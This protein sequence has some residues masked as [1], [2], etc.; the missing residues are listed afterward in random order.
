MIK[1][2]QL[3]EQFQNAI[4]RSQKEVKQIHQH[5]NELTWLPTCTSKM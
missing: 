3:S 5:G 4:E 2:I 1:D